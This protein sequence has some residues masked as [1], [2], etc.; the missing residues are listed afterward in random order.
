M[1]QMN[2]N[3]GTN[4]EMDVPQAP[5]NTPEV[6]TAFVT[7]MSVETS[8]D[9]NQTP[10]EP[11]HDVL[12]DVEGETKIDPSEAENELYKKYGLNELDEYI[13]GIGDLSYLELI[14]LRN[15]MHG[16]IERIES[17]KAAMDQLNSAAA[18]LNSAA[19]MANCLDHYG[20]DLTSDEFFEMYGLYMPKL[21]QIIDLC[22]MHIKGIG[23]RANST[24][25]MTAN[26]V[27][28]L[29]KRLYA[30]DNTNPEN[31]SKIKELA[32][33]IHIYNNRTDFEWIGKKLSNMIQNKKQLRMMAKTMSS[34]TISDMFGSLARHFAPVNLGG[35][36]TYMQDRLEYED[37]DI[38]ALLYC[39]NRILDVK[40]S[41]AEETWVK[42]F[43]L[44]ISD[45]MGNI[46]DLKVTAAELEESLDDLLANM[47]H[48]ASQYLFGTRKIKINAQ[49]MDFYAK[50]REKYIEAINEE[51]ARVKKQ[52]EMEAEEAAIMAAQGEAPSD[53]HHE[54][55][56]DAEPDGGSESEET[57]QEEAGEAA[58]SDTESDAGQDEGSEED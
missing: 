24:K 14:A 42:V 48:Q 5:E 37:G 44:N 29:E 33:N 9:P 1:E 46:Y 16:N 30:L 15:Q 17:C 25:Y 58:G 53:E 54:F 36:V 27:L 11:R 28:V 7:G 6:P 51:N 49:I 23:S 12:Q 31:A 39:L 40:V 3:P 34:G 10:E 2:P 21:R 50:L 19:A 45:I 8:E 56:H 20:I 4:P 32:T 57:A 38:L 18:K 22:T 26:M 13:N 43:V 35:F 41:G 55:M 47:L 52:Q